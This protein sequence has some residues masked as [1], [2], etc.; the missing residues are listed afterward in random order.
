[1]NDGIH[2][3]A[4]INKKF[5]YFSTIYFKITSA[6]NKTPLIKE[7]GKGNANTSS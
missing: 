7:G 1:M 2:K 3:V 6:K 5:H 4:T